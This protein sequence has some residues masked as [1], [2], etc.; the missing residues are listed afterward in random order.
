MKIFLLFAA[1][2][3]FVVIFL[4]V[5]GEMKA[6]GP[7]ASGGTLKKATL[8]GGCFWCMEKPFESLP[9]VVSVTSG[10]TG[11]SS[12][13]PTYETYGAA[14]H[15]EVV[16]IVYDESRISYEALLEV[17]WRQINPTD[18]GGQF[19]D[20]GAS[21]S[22]AIY[23]H[24]EEQKRL[25]EESRARLAGAGIFSDP[26]VTPILPASPFYPA[27]E[28]H[29]DYYKK[30]PLRYRFYRAGSGRDSFLA[31]V[32]A[33]RPDTGRGEEELRRRLTP[34]QY[35][36][37]QEEGT[38]PPFDNE[39]WDNKEPGIYLDVVSGEPLFSSLDKY[40]SGTGWP[41]FSRPLVA[42]NIIEHKDR[43]LFMVR[44]EVRSRQADS[45]LG[46]VF[47][48]GPP[49]TG[50]RYCINS[51]ALRFVPLAELEAAGYGEFRSLFGK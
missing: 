49:P 41:S 42:E 38:E 48:D 40:D 23:Y 25:A 28:Y 32:W 47:E 4:P 29:Q 7:P 46:H 51:A 5:Q 37:T 12:T 9:G 13:D 34:L 26:V 50:L 20:R 2:L 8:A 14:G 21:Y 33:D 19:A 17:F 36:V 30:N 39:Y 44:T 35:R 22:T 18:D 11:G 31:K 3:L 16:E 1:A 45:H 43:K 24:D 15:R 10:Y 6:G 27:E